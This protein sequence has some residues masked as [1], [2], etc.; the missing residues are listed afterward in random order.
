MSQAPA[1]SLRPDQHWAENVFNKIDGEMGDGPDLLDLPGLRTLRFK[2]TPHDVVVQ[3][4]T[5]HLP[6][7]CCPA[8]RG[9][10]FIRNGAPPHFVKDQPLLGRRARIFF[11]WQRYLCQT[12]GHSWQQPLPGINT[13][14]G[15][16]E[17]L[18]TYVERES[19]KMQSFARVAAESG[20]SPTTVGDIFTA[21]AVRLERTTGS[22]REIPSRIGIDECYVD[23]I[24]RFV[25]TDLGQRR[26]F[27]L[28]PKKDKLTVSKY[29]IQLP[30]PDLVKVLVM[31]MC[32]PYRDLVRQFLP[33]AKIVVD[34]FH[35]LRMANDAVMAVRRRIREGLPKV[36]RERCMP[37]S[38]P[39]KGKGK[40]SRFLLLKRAYRLSEKEEKTLW[41]W[42]EQ[43][44]EIKAA[45][46]FKEELYD[47]WELRDRREAE[48]R[49][50]DWARRVRA[51]PLDL[52]PAFHEL[53][54]AV[55]NWRAEVFNYFDHPFTNGQTEARNNVMKSMQ[56]QGR[57]YDFETVRVRMLYREE[58]LPPRPPH[59]LDKRRA[60]GPPPFGKKRLRRR[61]DPASPHS[62]VGKMRRA[63]K[64]NDV[65]TE[66]M[67]P[68]DGFI[69][70]FKH[71]TQ[72][73]LFW[74]LPGDGS[75]LE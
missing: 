54:R 52:Q 74:D 63:R 73:E 45:H 68:P 6:P 4:E 53:L 30:N 49:Y 58:V 39:R 19:M 22:A 1:S 62:N 15:V 18:V 13:R 60:G 75:G 28:L 33:Q 36:R 29:F 70:R 21:L 55:D 37:H 43:Y 12:C 48:R 47:L 67:R 26:T 72:M 17:R 7:N 59:P 16:T 23:G 51:H 25:I 56:R 3:A 38:A 27:E 10:L 71:F 2:K 46:E 66:L 40:R 35:V 50:A 8:C 41:E 24:P 61:P 65:F 5:T 42:K 14:S 69:E 57:G 32:K 20:L 64:E 9:F 31:D 34:K 11:K 44:P